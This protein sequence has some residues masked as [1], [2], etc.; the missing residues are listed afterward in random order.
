MHIERLIAGDDAKVI[1]AAELFDNVPGAEA[2]ADFLAR[3]DHYLHVAYDDE[4]VPAGFITGVLM[5]HPDKGREMFLYELGVAESHRGRG[6]GKA[7]V[8]QLEQVARGAGCYGLF[9]LTDVD[10]VAALATYGAAGA[11]DDGLHQM[12]AW[13]F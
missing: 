11:H 6:I 5:V 12:L 13:D 10:N 7:L 8:G 4:G 1:A 2:T 9:V 3:P